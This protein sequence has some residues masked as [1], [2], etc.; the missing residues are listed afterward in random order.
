MESIRD[1]ARLLRADDLRLA[2]TPLPSP[3][4]GPYSRES[5]STPS[6]SA[7][8]G[9]YHLHNKGSFLPLPYLDAGEPIV[10][11]FH[12]PASEVT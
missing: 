4:T 3:H 9:P 5:G 6:T 2:S 1:P 8:D 12:A 11:R 7:Q 10:I